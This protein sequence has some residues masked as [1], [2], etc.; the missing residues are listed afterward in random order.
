MAWLS[1]GWFGLTGIF[2]APA[3]LILLFPNGRLPTSN[4][5]AIAWLAVGDGL[6]PAR[7]RG[8]GSDPG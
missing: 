3:L 4:W 2:L 6:V 7:G 5:R 8:R 1:D